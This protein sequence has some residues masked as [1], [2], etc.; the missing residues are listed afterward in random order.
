MFAVSGATGLGAYTGGGGEGASGARTETC[1]GVYGVARAGGY[2]GDACK[3]RVYVMFASVALVLKWR[4][5]TTF[6]VDGRCCQCTVSR[7]LQ[8]LDYAMSPEPCTSVV[9]ARFRTPH[10]AA[11]CGTVPS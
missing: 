5:L 3:Q 8:F 4:K 1:I 7:A 6:Q 2:T 11:C 9:C 10:T